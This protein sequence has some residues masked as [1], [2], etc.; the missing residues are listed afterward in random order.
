MFTAD[1]ALLAL[2]LA[3]AQP[4]R[5]TFT[6]VF[7]AASPGEAIAVVVA[8]CTGCSWGKEGREAAALRVSLDGTYSQHLLLAR[9]ERPEEY[10]ITLGAVARGAH[11]VA[12][13][14][15][16]ALSAKNAGPAVIAAVDVEVLPAGSEA[17]LA[18]S[19]APVLH[20]RPNTVGRFTDLP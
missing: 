17:F 20:A 12:I 5:D 14:R 16:P 3:A 9:G 19:M 15:D 7:E 11:T 10:R 6:R 18:Q 8:G 2:A 13:E 4:A 1:T